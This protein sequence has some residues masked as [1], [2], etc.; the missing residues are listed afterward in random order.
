MARPFLTARW[1]NLCLVS[2]AVEPER[3]AGRLPPGLELDLR[4]GRAFVSLVAFD[5][6]DIRVLG[7]PWPGYRRF[8][9]VNLRFYVRHGQ[10]RGVVFVRE[11]VPR[12]LVA[13]IARALYNEPYRAARMASSVQVDATRI[14]VEHDIASGEKRGRL[15]VTGGSETVRP[16]DDSV[17]HFFKEHQ[18]GFGTDR[19]GRLQRY[20]VAHPVWEVH[21]VVD[22]SV[23]FDWA[24]L[25]GP[26][27]A[28]LRAAEPSS[29]VLAAGSEI[30]VYPL[31]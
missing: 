11:Y 5:F 28:D 16:R 12:R 8:P 18:W 9:E 3:L 25:Y 20:R 15:R 22:W 7:V 1:T 30:A 14:V 23:D 6:E 27:W 10:E 26:E 31:G 17:E 19:A 24:G 29:V 21:P 2:Y 4:D 13:W